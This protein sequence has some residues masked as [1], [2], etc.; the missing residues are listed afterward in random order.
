VTYQ[1][2]SYRVFIP[3]ESSPTTLTLRWEPGDAYAPKWVDGKQYIDGD[4]SAPDR[5]ATLV[6]DFIAQNDSIGYVNFSTS[7]PFDYNGN[8]TT[9]SEVT[10]ASATIQW[11]GSQDNEESFGQHANFTLNNVNYT[12]HFP[13]ESG[14]T[15]LLARGVEG[16][17]A[18]A[19][20]IHKQHEFHGRINGLWGVVIIAGTAAILLL[21]LA[22]LPRKE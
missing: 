9:F 16:Q 17:K 13:S 14:D 5:Q 1:N 8:E 21:G 22:Y 18:L 11:T 4:L 20:K 6:E 7:E 12:A 3:N 19:E 15:V 10:N 2:T